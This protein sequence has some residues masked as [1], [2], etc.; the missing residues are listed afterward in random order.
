SD[1]PN[2]AGK[3][4]ILRQVALISLLAQVGSFVP[5][6]DA[7]LGVVDRIFTRVGAVDDIGRGQSTFLVEMHETA[8]IL[9]QATPRSLVI[10]DEIGRGTSTFDGLALAWAVAEHLHDYAGLGVMTLFATHYHELTALSRL[11]SRV[12]NQHVAVVEADGQIV[13]LHQLRPGAANKSYGIQV[14]RLAGVPD[15]VIERAQEVLENIEAGTLD[16]LGFP[17][18]ARPRRRAAPPDTGQLGLFSGSGP[19]TASGNPPD[20]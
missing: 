11:K 18:L 1:L 8:N 4:T 15:G 3:S 17:R 9:H 16:Q 12:Q 14:A 19:R 2:M 6:A 10:L 7:V 13:F 20:H 5:A